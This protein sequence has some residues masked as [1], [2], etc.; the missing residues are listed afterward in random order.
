MGRFVFF[1]AKTIPDFYPSNVES[2]KSFV[3]C[4]NLKCIYIYI[5][6]TVFIEV[7][8]FKCFKYK[9]IHIYI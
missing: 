8:L 2:F 5:F 3:V 4:V 7:Q 9:V 6:Y 1:Q